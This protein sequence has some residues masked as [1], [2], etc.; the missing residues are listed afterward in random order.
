[1]LLRLFA[2][3]ALVATI[4]AAPQDGYLKC[5]SEPTEEIIAA[6]EMMAVEESSSNF[7]FHP[8]RESIEVDVYFH[9]IAG[10]NEPR[11]PDSMLNDQL[12]VLNNDFAP[13][14]FHFNLKGTT[15][16]VDSVWARDG[17]EKGMKKFLRKGTYR[18]L[19]LYFVK[20]LGDL[21]GYCYPP[22]GGAKEG[23]GRFLKDGCTIC[24]AAM[25]GGAWKSPGHTVTHEVGHWLGLLHTFHGFSCH[26]YG[27][28]IGDTPQQSRPS[29][30]GCHE[31]SDS[32]PKQPGLDPVHNYMDYSRDT[33]RTEFTHG[34]YTRM[35]RI[36][37]KYR[38]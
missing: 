28:Y 8:T 2:L 29:R 36:W 26:G 13:Q 14:G 5:G 21:A 1:M 7:T 17:D 33:C 37:K 27:D 25:P 23:S 3:T 38:E 16:T 18:T 32:C 12:N 6:L 9:V 24:S 4:L 19:N 35:H 30:G 22:T 10:V 31:D 11:M 20:E 15:R 34:Q